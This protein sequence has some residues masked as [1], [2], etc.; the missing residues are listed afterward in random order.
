MYGTVF[1]TLRSRVPFSAATIRSGSLTE[2]ASSAVEVGEL[3]GEPCTHV[4]LAHVRLQRRRPARAL[5]GRHLERLGERVRLS[6]DVEGVDA[7]REQAELV[8]RADVLREH[9]HPVAGVDQR[10]LL[11]DQ[12]HPI[13]KRVDQEHVVLPVGSDGLREVIVDSQVDGGSAVGRGPALADRARRALDRREVVGV[14]GDL[15]PRR[16]EQDEEAHA[17]PPLRLL[18]EE[19]V[20]RLQAAHDVLRRIGAVDAQDRAARAARRPATCSAACT[21]GDA[22]RPSNS[23]ASTEIGYARTSVSRPSAWTR[24]A[25]PV[26]RRAGQRLAE[27]EELASRSPRCGTRRRRR[28]AGRARSPRASRWAARARRPRPGHGM[29]TKCESTRSGRAARTSAATR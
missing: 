8:V 28:R 20:E 1:E 25:L 23:S 27:R 2:L 12:I 3:P 15:E 5:G 29:C 6:L 17:A 22:T 14:L 9:Q 16:I 26:D 21:A 7:D 11:G 19:P 13:R 10:S 24:A 4:V 18:L